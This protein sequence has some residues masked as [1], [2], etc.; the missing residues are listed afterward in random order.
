MSLDDQHS[1]MH[2]IITI[3]IVEDNPLAAEFLSEVLS[4]AGYAVR[5]YGDGR[6][7]VA[8]I[9]EQPPAMVLLDLELPAMP[10]EEVLTHV[11]RQLGAKLPIVIMTASTRRW[12]WATQGATA[13]LAKPFD[14]AELL[15]CVARYAASGDDVQLHR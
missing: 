2:R 4:E 9:I 5:V 13:F 6:S 3:T 8:A 1:A 7:A 11:R 12:D 14:M 10:G 15:R